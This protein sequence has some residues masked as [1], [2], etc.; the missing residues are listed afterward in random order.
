MLPV[1]TAIDLREILQKGGRTKP[2]VVLVD[3]NVNGLATY[4]VKIFTNEQIVSRN[5]VENEVLGNIL[6]RE[7]GLPTPDGALIEFS[8]DFIIRLKDEAQ[9]ILENRD[10]RIKFGS[11]LIEPADPFDADMPKA[12]MKKKI[13]LDSVFAFDNLIR[14]R[15]RG[16]QKPNLILS[17]KSA[18]LIDHELGFEKIEN[19]IAELQSGNLDIKF[20]E[21]HIFYH[22][23][24]RAKATT[25]SQYFEEF[26]EYLR[27]LN[28][29]VLNQYFTQLESFGYVTR[30]DIIAQ[31][32]TYVKE[33]SA[34]F[35]TLLRKNLR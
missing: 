26:G 23:L 30:K 25:K 28:V 19:A 33:N 12:I 13:D 31:Y 5:S 1:Y 7:F 34:K 4:V 17:H 14:N 20:S 9:V 35:V 10:G 27:F 6:A 29:N 32:L 24:R 11:L 15:D 2:W 18:F 21:W 3:A 8:N 22:Y 16:S